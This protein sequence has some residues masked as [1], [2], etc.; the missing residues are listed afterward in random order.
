MPFG[1]VHA[2]FFFARARWEYSS[3][4]HRSLINNMEPQSHFHFLLPCGPQHTSISS[5]LPPP[6]KISRNIHRNINPLITNIFFP[7]FL[8]LAFPKLP[9]QHGAARLGMASH[10]L[11]HTQVQVRISFIHS[12]SSE[13]GT[14]LI[15]SVN[16][17]SSESRP[18]RLHF[19]MLAQP[20][21][22]WVDCTGPD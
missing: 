7:S 5:Q 3:N 20:A 2:F 10:Y 21:T 11:T 14:H 22:G 15:H 8:S 18:A 1:S 6:D 4:Y 9:V 19:S 13:T 17:F 16:F 12:H